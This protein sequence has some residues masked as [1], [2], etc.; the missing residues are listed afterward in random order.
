MKISIQGSF[1]PKTPNF[2]EV[3]QVPHSGQATGQGI[4]CL[5]CVVVQGPGSFRYLVNFS[6]R[7]T[8]AELRGYKVAQFSDFGLFSPYKTRKMYLPVKSLQLRGYIFH[9]VVEGPKGCLPGPEFSCD[10]W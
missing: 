8:V 5:I 10:F 6:V 4:H 3:K 2:E 1:A 9:V 7:R